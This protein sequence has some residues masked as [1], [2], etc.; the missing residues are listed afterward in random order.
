MFERAANALRV[1]ERFK[2]LLVDCFASEEV[3]SE[4][5]HIYLVAPP[6]PART[7][8]GTVLIFGT[9]TPGRDLVSH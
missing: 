8:H 9:R 6:D 7:A 4:H 2:P 1:G 3:G 5:S